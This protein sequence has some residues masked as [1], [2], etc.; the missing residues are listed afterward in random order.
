[1]ADRLLLHAC[2]GP[3]FLYPESTLSSDWKITVY[4]DNPNIHPR[5]EWAKRRDTLVRY[6][7]KKGIDVAVADYRPDTWS[8][9]VLTGD[10]D[11][12]PGRCAAC[13]AIRLMATAEL[14]AIEGFDAFTTTLLVSPHQDHEAVL[15]A[16]RQA[17]EVHG[18]RFLEEDFR[19]GY[20]WGVARS[21]ELG[22]YRQNYCGCVLSLIERGEMKRRTGG[23]T[24][25]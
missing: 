5:W 11:R 23:M 9:E 7:A 8:H 2:C 3:C 15:A 17:A 25:R 21:K 18:V 22:M 12:A 19:E 16:G 4:F 24:V 20:R 6:A 13:Y 1:M 10:S 14:A